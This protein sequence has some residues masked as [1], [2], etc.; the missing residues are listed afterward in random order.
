MAKT[1]KRKY[2]KKRKTMRRRKGGIRPANPGH[3]INNPGWGWGG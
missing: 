3:P 1:I 2:Q